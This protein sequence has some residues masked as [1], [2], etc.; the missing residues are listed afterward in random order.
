MRR[1]ADTPKI[2]KAIKVSAVV[3][4]VYVSSPIVDPDATNDKIH[5][6]RYRFH[7]K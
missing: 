2:Q 7:R 6:T 1:L 3:E 5:A 4:A